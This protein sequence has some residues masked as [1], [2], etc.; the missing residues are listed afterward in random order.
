MNEKPCWPTGKL[1][2]VKCIDIIEQVSEL[3]ITSRILGLST[4]K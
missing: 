3:K 1:T 4:C 2:F